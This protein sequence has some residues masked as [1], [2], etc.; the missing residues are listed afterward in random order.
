M[1]AALFVAL[2]ASQTTGDVFAAMA[3]DSYVDCLRSKS[4]RP[5]LERRIADEQVRL[6]GLQCRTLREAMVESFI[7][8]VP[9][10]LETRE[11]RRQEA[12]RGAAA[13][14]SGVAHWLTLKPLV[15]VPSQPK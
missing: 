8:L 15:I 11:A 7:P 12:E 1:I 6:A 5:P 13:I 14:D 4:A 9:E 2:L 3:I 10:A